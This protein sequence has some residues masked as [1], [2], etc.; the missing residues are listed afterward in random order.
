MAYRNEAD[1]VCSTVRPLYTAVFELASTVAV[2]VLFAEIGSAVGDHAV[3]LPDS[4]EKMNS[5]GPLPALVVTTKS[6][7]AF[8][9]W[10]VGAPPG[11]VTTRPAF[12]TT[13]RG[14]SE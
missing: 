2:E 4:E 6:V 3:I 14:A 8:A 5:A 7:P 10:P 12:V 11:I 9:T 13:P 1:F